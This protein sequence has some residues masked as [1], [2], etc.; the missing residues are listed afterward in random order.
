LRSEGRWSSAEGRHHDQADEGVEHAVADLQAAD[1]GVGETPGQSLERP[2]QVKRVEGGEGGQ[3][4]RDDSL[5]GEEKKKDVSQG[6]EDQAGGEDAAL[7]EARRVGPD[8]VEDVALVVPELLSQ[9]TGGEGQAE[10]GGRGEAANV[11][12]VPEGVAEEE[13]EGASHQMGR[14][15]EERPA[16][17]VEGGQGVEGAQS[18]DSQSEAEGARA[19]AAEEEE[20]QSQETGR[21]PADLA[22]ADTS[23]REDAGGFVGIGEV[24]RQA[25]PVVEQEDVGHQ[26][27]V[28]DEEERERSPVRRRGKADREGGAE[29]GRAL[30]EEDLVQAQAGQ[31]ARRSCFSGDGPVHGRA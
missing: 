9:V 10:E 25:G 6:E 11:D 2:A 13:V 29:Q 15:A 24:G 21:Q 22:A 4:T 14:G 18:S 27:D 3:R 8:G 16:F 7:A 12:P 28:G 20:T 23:G 19:E 1:A 31:V 17:P 5:E 30:E 26:A